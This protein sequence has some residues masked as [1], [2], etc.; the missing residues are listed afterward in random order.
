MNEPTSIRPE[1]Y[2]R[3][4]NPFFGVEFLL[5]GLLK[6]FPERSPHEIHGIVEDVLEQMKPS[7][8]RVVL[9]RISIHLLKRWDQHGNRPGQ[10]DIVE[11]IPAQILNSRRRTR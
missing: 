11:A 1:T 3:R 4:G 7:R 6:R 9:E 2:G 5:R 8:G 10:S